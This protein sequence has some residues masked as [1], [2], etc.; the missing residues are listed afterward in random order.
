MTDALLDAASLILFAP[1]EPAKPDAPPRLLII[2]RSAALRF[3][4]GA[5]AFPGGRVDPGDVALA[6][7]LGDREAAP[8]IAAIRETI[9]ET[10][11]AIGVS[12]VPAPDGLARLRAGLA[13]GEPFAALLAE[14]GLA[15][16]PRALTS[17]ARW[18][19]PAGTARRFDTR[20]YLATADGA[21]VPAPDAAETA[22]AYWMSAADALAAIA[23]GAARA[24]F[25][26]IC[27]LERLAALG[28]F[29]TAYADATQRPEKIVATWREERDGQSWLCIPDDL[30]YPVTARPMPQG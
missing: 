12:P 11:I 6:L 17:F 19:P 15:L 7:E 8:R 20:F 10:G 23:A 24:M 16:E 26:T 25:P 29:E 5:L 28:A 2:E 27:L 3:G 18:C 30:G 4:G 21:A 14:A 13:A 22:R 1:S 9:E